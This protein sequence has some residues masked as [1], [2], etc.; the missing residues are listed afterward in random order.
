MG[1]LG[2]ERSKLVLNVAQKL[3]KNACFVDFFHSL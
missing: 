3:P 2:E 1:M